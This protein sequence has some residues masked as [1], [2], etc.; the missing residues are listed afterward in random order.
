MSFHA[1]FYPQSIAVIGASRKEKTVGN[2]VA[3]NILSGKYA[4]KVFLVNPK[5]DI[6]YDQKVFASTLDLPEKI[7]LAIIAVPA[8]QV[9][10][11]IREASQKGTEAAIILSAGFRE[12]GNAELEK[13]IVELCEEKG[14]TLV[15]PNC[16]G[17]L[18][19]EIGLNASFASF[20]PEIGKIA[21]ISQSG[22]LCTSVLDYAADLGLGFS[23]FL[24]IGNK[25]D[26]DELKLLKYFAEDPKTKVIAIYTEQ[27]NNASEFIAAVR[28]ITTGENPK[29]VIILKSGK[30]QEGREAVASHTGSLSG[31]EAVYTALFEQAGAIQVQ[32]IS[33]L[34]EYLQIFSFNTLVPVKNIAIVTNAGGPGVLTTDM[35]VKSD[36]EMAVLSESTT[37]A[38]KSFL[39]SAASTHNPID[40]LGDARS[41]RYSQVVERVAQDPNV[42]AIIVILTPQS[43]TDEQAI[44]QVLVEI[45]KETQKP[46][47]VSFMGKKAVE[48]GVN[49]LKAQKIYTSSFPETLVQALAA[50]GKFFEKAQR[51][52]SPLL[53][54]EDVDTEVVRGIFAKA[55]TEGK[56]TFLGSEAIEIL[57]AYRFPFL[58]VARAYSPQETRE[59]VLDLVGTDGACAMKIISQDISHKSDVGGVILN[60]TPESVEED[61]RK[62]MNTLSINAPQAKLEGVLLME[63]ASKNGVE[64]I[65]GVN[66]V[67][68]L[69]TAVMMGFGGI[70]VEVLKDVSFG[71]LPLTHQNVVEMMQQLRSFKILEGARGQEPAD[72][73][74]LI[75]SVGRLSQLA[76][77]FPQI[78]E[79]DINPLLVLPEGQGVKALDAR[80]VLG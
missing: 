22:A 11:S 41:D 76:A 65:L 56:K 63:M 29:P 44:A 51:V 6:L 75:E 47:G 27:L 21:F 23:K 24:S 30:T 25:A 4:G 28:E 37:A 79:L 67:L 15:G 80:I 9:V 33:Q 10:E 68:G 52:Q 53:N 1:L 14:I 66:K 7:D 31:S 35:V 57:Q 8:S 26:I 48:E 19:P 42:D 46:F 18:N 39:P 64:M 72:R 20:L 58:R 16:L 40:I 2:D 55:A 77:D 61:Y 73:E 34:F 70:Y 36:L 49:I 71:F 78:L 32:S 38:L 45:Q 3:K 59:K 5:A 13:E 43:M 60:V 69:G 17:V 62:M 74:K 54:F 50:F 12:S